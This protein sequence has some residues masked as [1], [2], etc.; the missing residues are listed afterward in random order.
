MPDGPMVPANCLYAASTSSA[1]DLARTAASSFRFAAARPAALTGQLKPC[2]TFS[3]SKNHWITSISVIT[4]S[5][6]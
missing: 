3:K 1:E 4:N 2:D 6:L 5:P